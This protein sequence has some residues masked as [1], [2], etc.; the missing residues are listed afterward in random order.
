VTAIIIARIGNIELP[1][2]LRQIGLGRL[3]NQMKM[4]AHEDIGVHTDAENLKRAP[5]S[6]QKPRPVMIV[7]KDDAPVIAPAS[8]MIKSIGVRDS[9]WPRHNA[10]YHSRSSVQL[11]RFK[12][13]CS[14]VQRQILRRE[15]CTF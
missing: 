2:E 3:D 5:E 12:V 7:A 13:Q 10:L 15:T 14:K 6:I 9:Q 11:R 1:H 4:I 8:Y